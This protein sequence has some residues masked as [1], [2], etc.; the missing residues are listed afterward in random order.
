MLIDK[1]YTSE[2]LFLLV[3][4]NPLPNYVAGHLLLAEKG[5]I[6]LIYS[7][8]TSKYAEWLADALKANLLTNGIP[9]DEFARDPQ[10]V[11]EKISSKIQNIYKTAQQQDL[12]KPSI[13]LHYTGGT[14]VMS[15]HAYRAV[16]ESSPDA[17]CSYLD[18]DA[19]QLS[20]EQNGSG[21]NVPIRLM[22]KETNTI[23]Q[24][25]LKDLWKLHGMKYDPD[26][27]RQKPF[28]VQAPQI[29]AY[30]FAAGK[31][32]DWS[33]AITGSGKL[34][35]LAIQPTDPIGNLPFP[36]VVKAFTD[37]Q[38]HIKTYQD[39]TDYLGSRATNWL[40]G[41]DWLE[42]FVLQ[43]L[44]DLA[45]KLY[46]SN[47]TC[48]AATRKGL[49]QRQMEL[50]VAA[51]RGHQ[52]FLFSCYAGKDKDVCKSKLFEVSHRAHQLGGSEAR[53]TLVCGH[54]DVEEIRQEI[55][56]YLSN[57]EVFGLPDF[58]TLCQKIHTWILTVDRE[59]VA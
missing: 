49:G 22:P 30:H 7:Q 25:T 38:P 8:T 29:L 34:R 6:Y 57:F 41:G 55:K 46:L 3:G 50:D 10:I 31:R 56:G 32:E 47:I 20:F 33:N 43:C 58:P 12:K 15:V 39:L 28:F 23:L 59:N 44:L 13:G 24:L 16:I 37:E 26:T 11:F 35:K 27:V 18:P 19:L 40:G 21:L 45:D 9:L 42:D 54:P 48:S 36:D 1:A 51:I 4:T 17:L 53:F 2:H 14:K 5:T 52:L